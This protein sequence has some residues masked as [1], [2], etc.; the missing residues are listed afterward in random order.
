[1]TEK[2][3]AFNAEILL[4][5]TN[6]NKVTAIKLL[7]QF[8]ETELEFA[9][10]FCDALSLDKEEAYRQAH[11]IKS[12]LA[13]IGAMSAH[14]IAV[15]LDAACKMET[16]ASELCQLANQINVEIHAACEEI[17]FF[18]SKNKPPRSQNTEKTEIQ[19]MHQELIELASEQNFKALALSEKLMNTTDGKRAKQYQYINQQLQ[20]L[21]FD[22]AISWLK[23]IHF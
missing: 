18:L 7:R 17:N 4:H 2:P 12:S 14:D 21:E 1:M 16:S 8:K 3:N 5:N 6:Q 10:R 19:N 20:D 23:K 11:S 15:Q 9:Q 13:L 22:E